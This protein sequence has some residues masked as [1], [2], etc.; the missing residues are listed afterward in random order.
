MILDDG[1][2]TI[3]RVRE[4]GTT[5]GELQEVAQVW[6]KGLDYSSSP[7]GE[8]YRVDTA[9]ERRIRVLRQNGLTAL[10]AVLIDGERYEVV[11]IYHGTDD[12]NGQPITDLTLRQIHQELEVDRYA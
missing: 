2:C 1:I 3:C 5:A 9:L 12:D 8:E 6:Y 4:N 11:R 7:Y 10:Y